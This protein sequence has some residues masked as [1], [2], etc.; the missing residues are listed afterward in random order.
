MGPCSTS[1]THL[2]RPSDTSEAYASRH[3]LLPF[4]QYI[5]LTH[6]DTYIYGP[7]NFATIHGCKSCD[8]V[9]SANWNIIQSHTEMFHNSIPSVKVATYSVHVDACT[10]TTFYNGFLLGN[11]SLQCTSK[12]EYKQLYP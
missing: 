7:F 11:M 10:H 6:L 1:N 4:Q 2:I 8:H 5:H 12:T 3:K 9:G